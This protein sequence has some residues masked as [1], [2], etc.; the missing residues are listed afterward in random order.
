MKS[1]RAPIITLLALYAAFAGS[2]FYAAGKLPDRV[3]S[4]F[5][6]HGEPNAWMSRT[7]DLVFF[8]AAGVGIPMLIIGL[9]YAIKYLPNSLVNLPRREYWLAPERHAETCRYIRTRSLW[10]AAMSLA[11][12]TALNLVVVFANRQPSVQ[13]SMP[14]LYAVTGTFLLATVA[15]VWG[16]FRHFDPLA[17][18]SNRSA[19]PGLVMLLLLAVLVPSLCLLW[20]MNQAVKSER[21][22]AR[23]KLIEAYRGQLAIAQERLE[24]RL[25][26]ISLGMEDL[27]QSN[28][29]AAVFA[30]AVRSNLADAVICL[31]TNGRVVYPASTLPPKPEILPAGWMEAQQIEFS[32]P[33]AAATAFSRLAEQAT[34]AALIARASQA[35]ARCLLRAGQKEAAIS[36]LDRALANQNLA[37][38]L[39]SQGRLIIADLELMALELYDQAASTRKSEVVDKLKQQLLDYDADSMPASQRRFLMREVQRLFPNQIKFPVLDAEDLAIR[40]VENA[41]LHG[42]EQGVLRSSALPGVW[43]FNSA[44]G[45]VILLHQA[46][47]LE[48]RLVSWV[49]SQ[50]LPTDV[51]LVAL[52]PGRASNDLLLPTPAGSALP[53]WRVA[54]SLK[55]KRLFDAAVDQRIAS[56]VWIGVLVLGSVLVLASLI[57]RLVRKQLAL[58][59]LRNDLVANVTHELKTPLSSMRLLVDTLLNSNQWNQ[60]TTREYLQLIATENL[61]LSR[62]IDNFLT[63]SRIERNKYTFKFKELPPDQIAE[64][65]AASVRDRFSIPGCRFEL[66]TA[67]GLPLVVADDDAIVTVLLNLLDNAFKYSGEQKHISLG[68]IAQNGSVRFT[69]TDNGI[70]LSPRD[71][72][73]IFKRFYQVDQRLSRTG[74][75]CGLGLSIVK[76]IVTAHH[77][78]VEVE[79]QPGK[80]SV[81]TVVLPAKGPANQQN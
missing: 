16:L 26:Q 66:H 58:T 73:R 74:G 60:K 33:A 24:N 8:A 21:A 75:G 63:F 78:N 55:D 43:Q 79:S 13:L 22:G 48:A 39:D 47:K 51:N 80:G 36:A 15:W 77:G 12:L 40:F 76:F 28:A 11:L 37:K 2:L 9:A 49:P 7:G 34:N 29:P 25:R 4:H 41:P 56:Y 53:G 72:K 44:R 81:F 65:A 27:L 46:E 32:D 5:G 30:N 3:A 14:L 19:G 70:G 45:R 42:G 38:A 54:L 6:L 10:F 18:D 31:N 69:V 57:L 61:R 20:F 52:A 68:A 62:L 35:E 50:T 23:Q 71:T 64:Q 67:R 17:P 59:Q 1:S